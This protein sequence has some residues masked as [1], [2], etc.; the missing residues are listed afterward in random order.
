MIWPTDS[1][2][3]GRIEFTVTTDA[4]GQ[5]FE[6]NAAGTA[7]TNNATQVVVLSAPDLTVTALA[8]DNLTPQ[9]GAQITITWTDVNAG[10]AQVTAGWFD[11]VLIT[12]QTTGA[13]L[14][15]QQARRG[16]E[17]R[18]RDVPA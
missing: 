9:S 12:N 5:L 2:G 15:N 18:R 1:S 4:A 8:V 14:A 6:N 11:R 17:L 16:P 7:E 10:T 13:Q 3:V